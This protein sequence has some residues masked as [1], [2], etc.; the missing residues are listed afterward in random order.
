MNELETVD[1]VTLVGDEDQATSERGLAR[2]SLFRSDFCSELDAPTNDATCCGGDRRGQVFK[3][4][5]RVSLARVRSKWTPIF[6]L[7]IAREGIAEVVVL[8][9]VSAKSRVV[10]ERR[11]IDRSAFIIYDEQNSRTCSV[12]QAHR[13]SI[14][15]LDGLREARYHQQATDQLR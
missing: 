11:N 5:T 12:S 1:D 3:V 10:L 15:R 8:G 4:S 13:S 7:G 2:G 6:G 9:R 14:D